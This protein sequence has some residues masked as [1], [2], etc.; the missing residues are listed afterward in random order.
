M[1]RNLDGMKNISGGVLE[2]KLNECTSGKNNVACPKFL[3]IQLKI[4]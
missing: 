4:T 1:F 3:N 2:Q